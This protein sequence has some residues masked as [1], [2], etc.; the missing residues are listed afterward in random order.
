MRRNDP[1]VFVTVDP[2]APE[3]VYEQVAQQIRER[4]ASGA[5]PPGTLLP[6]VRTLASDLGYNLNTVARAYRLLETDGFVRIR[7]RSGVEVAPPGSAPPSG[8]RERVGSD[9]R[10]ALARLRQI[11]V[12]PDEIRR[13]VEREIAALGGANERGG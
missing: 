6:P 3:P 8:A 4:I 1:I 7:E 9:L 13:I 12:K 10:Q 5:L 2:E 11:G